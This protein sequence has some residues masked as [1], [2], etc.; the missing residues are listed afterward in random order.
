MSYS[1]DAVVQVEDVEVVRRS[2]I[3][4]YC[5]IQGRTVLVTVLQVAPGFLMP[6]EGRHGPIRI[7]GSALPDLQLAPPLKRQA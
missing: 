3:G 5:T 2:D 7:R 6:A 4:W 1:D